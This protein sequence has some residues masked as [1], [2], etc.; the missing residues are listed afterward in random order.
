VSFLAP[1]GRAVVVA[2]HSLEDRVV[3]RFLR[4]D[5]RVRILTKRPLRPSDDEVARNPRSRSARLR[6]AERIGEA[7]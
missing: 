1:G 4:D 2:Y 3:K 5:D 7:A 6:A